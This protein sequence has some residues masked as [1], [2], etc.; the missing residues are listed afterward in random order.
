MPP[1][2]ARSSRISRSHVGGPAYRGDLLGNGGVCISRYG[3]I[4]DAATFQPVAGAS[5]RVGGRTMVTGTDGWYRIDLG[6]VDNPINNFGTTFMY[7]AASR[8]PRA[9][10]G[11]RAWD[12]PRQPRRRGIAASRSVER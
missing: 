1:S 3:V 2:M 8:L 5:V 12:P 11:P 9:L 4:T 7:V 10:T 6:C